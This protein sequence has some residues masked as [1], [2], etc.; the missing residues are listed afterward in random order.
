MVRTTTAAWLRGR[1]SGA[2][3]TTA[4]ASSATAPPMT[5]SNQRV[6]A[7]PGVATK[8]TTKI[9]C[10]AAWVTSSPPASRNSAA[11]M[12]TRTMTPICQAPVPTSMRNRSAMSRPTAT[13]T[14]ISATRRSRCAYVVPRQTTATI[15][16]NTGAWWWNTPLARNQASAAAMAH[17]PMCHALPRTRSTRSRTETRPRRQARSIERVDPVVRPG[18]A[19]VAD[20][21]IGYA[22]SVGGAGCQPAARNAS[23]IARDAGAAVLAPVPACATMT[24]TA[25]RGFVTGPNEANQLVACLPNTSADPVFPASG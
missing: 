2:A 12:A 8:A 18:R 23:Q 20:P 21:P 22:R 10:T 9:D 24:T 7:S 25:Y 4:A 1:R 15:G 3:G 14:V 17:W 11:D 5:A 19:H 13:P 16:A 6:S